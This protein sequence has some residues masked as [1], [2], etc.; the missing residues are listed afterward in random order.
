MKAVDLRAKAILSRLGASPKGAELGVY[1]GALAMRLLTRRDLHLTMVDKWGGHSESYADADMLAPLG[2]EEW[3][4]IREAADVHTRFAEDRRRII[5]GDT[6]SSAREIADGSL[7][8]VFVDADH[9][10]EGCYR[11]LLAWIGKIKHGGLLC[12]HDYFSPDFPEWGVQ[13][14]VNEFAQARGLTVELDDDDTWFIRLPGPLPEPSSEYDQIVV[15]CVYWRGQGKPKY[16]PEYVNIL[17]DMVARNCELPFQFWCFTDD[18]AGLAEEIIVKPLPNGLDGWWNKLCLFKHD[19]FLPKTR[20]IYLDLDIVVTAPIEPLINTKGIVADWLQGGYNSS[21]MVWDSGEFEFL[22]ERFSPGYAD[23]L[24]GD[25][26]YITEQSEW[27]LL[28]PDWIVSYRLHAHEWP[29]KDA[30]VVAFHGEPKPHEVPSGWVPEMWT[31][32]GLAIPR[33]TSVLNNDIQTIR[34]NVAINKARDIPSCKEAPAHDRVLVI[35]AGGPSLADNVGLIALEQAYGAEVWALNGAHDFLIDH[36]IKPTAMV[37]LDSR[38]ECVDAFLAHPHPGV[39][40]LISTQCDPDAF[41]CLHEQEWFWGEEPYSVKKWTGWYWG[42]EDDL[43]IGGGA[44]VGLKS[45]MLAAAMGYRH[46]KLFGYDSSY[47]DGVDHAYPQP[48]NASD[49]RVDVVLYGRKFTCARWMAKQ[50][51][52]FLAAAQALTE[53]WGCTIEICG[54]GLLPYAA[55]IARRERIAA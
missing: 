19:V 53:Q 11:D 51:V 13:R 43:V 34:R 40:Y 21:V 5:Q 39:E 2:E 50:V 14:A 54:D 1:R 47:R 55:S 44:T 52:E 29:P 48:L 16:G 38:R 22:W 42:V 4:N 18:P 10:Y 20:V 12:G 26:D 35:A 8:F 36:G 15:A 6:V 25:Q 3:H 33:Y 23:R 28:P 9:S 49:L 41:D 32:A 31:M 7:D 27:P 24:H 30:I 17:A 37:M 45:I 46:F